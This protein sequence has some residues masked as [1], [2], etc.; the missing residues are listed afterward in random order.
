MVTSR[1]RLIWFSPLL[2]SLLVACGSG[3][4]GTAISTA[5]QA[6]PA[7]T[8]ALPSTALA[9]S[10]GCSA[11]GNPT[12]FTAP[13]P[14]ATFAGNVRI[15][16]SGDGFSAS[17]I[18]VGEATFVPLPLD[19]ADDGVTT[20]TADA[21]SQFVDLG[22]V[23]SFAMTDAAVSAETCVKVF[24]LADASATL[25]VPDAV[26]NLYRNDPTQIT[27]SDIGVQVA[28]RQLVEMGMDLTPQNLADQANALLPGTADDV[29]A[30]NLTEG[31]VQ[32]DFNFVA[33]EDLTLADTGVLIA[34]RVLIAFGDEPS[35][36]NIQLQANVLLP[37]EEND[38]ADPAD[39]TTVPVDNPGAQGNCSFDPSFTFL[40]D[41]DA[42]LSMDEAVFTVQ[43]LHAADQEAGVAA[44][45]DA[46]RF[47]AIM[48]GLESLFPNNLLLTSGDLWIPGPFYSAGGDANGRGGEADVRINSAIGW[49]AAVLGNHEFDLGTD[50]L[51]S[52]IEADPGDDFPGTLFPYLGAANLDFTADGNLS[53]LVVAGGQEANTIPNSIAPS[54]VVTVGDEQ[55]GI[56]GATTPTL[57]QISS[58]GG[59]D[60]LPDGFINL[61]PASI[62]ALAEEIQPE[63]NELIDLGIDKIVLISHLQQLDNEVLLASE[64]TGVDIVIGG[65]SDTLLA[66]PGNRIRTEFGKDPSG[67]Y[68]VLLQSATG[69]PVAL[70]NSDREYRYVNRLIVG[71]DANGLLAE[72]SPE[73]RPYPADSQGVSEV[74][75]LAGSG[76]TVPDQEVT[77]AITEVSNVLIELDG[78]IAGQTD[79]FLNGE[80]Q[81]VRT[82]ETN[83]GNVTAD[84]NLFE[85]RQTDPMTAVSLKN[86]GGIRA[87][88]GAIL[89]GEE[90]VRVPP[91]ANPLTGKEDGDVSLLDIQNALRFNNGLVLLTVSAAELKDIIEHGLANIGGGQT[92]QVGGIRLSYDPAGTAIAFDADGTVTTPGTRVQSLAIVDDT[93]AVTDVIVEAGAVAGDPERPIRIV[94]LNFLAD[95]D[96]ETPGL[97]G[98]GYPYPAFGENRV[99]LF[100]GAEDTPFGP[101][102]REQNALADFLA[103]SSPVMD[104]DTP[105]EEDERIQNLDVRADTVLD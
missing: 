26:S 50:P 59:V 87:S 57:Q 97:G 86:G 42:A 61:D 100:E 65:G 45:E 92:L 8:V 73:S 62:Q 89:P 55:I 81:D 90:G 32:A 47:S 46:P 17:A 66:N 85:A 13:I 28:A 21:E 34:N 96:D 6:V 99:D 19:P 3:G 54:T 95:A 16:V 30:D 15:E 29:S 44:I 52:L 58:P 63:I 84:A 20:Y 70:V 11:A 22:G 71:F 76:V 80:R 67:P 33:P 104:A 72:I 35:A 75:N 40:C 7:T 74:A 60:A 102:G 93:G 18:T 94:T 82:Q 64:L 69:E 27:L 2:L 41:P 105:P 48:N 77:D 24:D 1:M 88:I 25:M 38:I 36:E 68:P 5:P 98:D 103:V 51:E 101:D 39:I 79:V 56:V 14:A 53:N 23:S 37:G 43:V 83:L 49:D 91:L 31:L 9:E 10:N 78:T 4:G 12:S